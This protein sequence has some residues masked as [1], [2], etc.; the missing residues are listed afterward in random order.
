MTAPVKLWENVDALV[1][2]APDAV[3]LR[4]HRLELLAGRQRRVVGLP[5]DP[6]LHEDERLS[7]LRTMAAGHLLT[8]I[9]AAGD[10]ALLLVKGPEVAACYPRPDCRPFKDLDIISAHPE[11]TQAGLIRS[12]FVEI[13]SLGSAPHH[14]FPLVWPGV[15]V[16]VEI[17]SAPHCVPGLVAPPVDRLLEQARPSLTGVSGLDAL[18][19]AAHAV[20]LAMHGWAHGPL[21]CLG[22]LIDVAAVLGEGDRANADAVAADWG[23]SRLWR[24][25]IAGI[26]GVLLG[27]RGALHMRVWARHLRRARQPRVLETYL[28][29]LAAPAWALPPTAVV[30]GVSA[31]LR[32]TLL[33]YEE[34]SWP[35]QLTR[36]RRALARTFR[37]VSEYRE[38]LV[39]EENRHDPVFA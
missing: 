25:T 30:S 20:L 11:A 16:L 9:R 3:A 24:S 1:A 12:G 6:A 18:D 7:A 13:R 27:G 21:D 39:H 8:R 35:A 19:P 36:N 26:D 23:C 5:P 33:P 38:T 31:E 4:H 2:R 22:H 28:A 37:P 32:R 10:E 14:M 29:R 34:E 15:P 17:H